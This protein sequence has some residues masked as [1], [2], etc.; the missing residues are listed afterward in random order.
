[1]KKKSKYGESARRPSFR[2]INLFEVMSKEEE[3]QSK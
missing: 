3:V 1:M 2:A